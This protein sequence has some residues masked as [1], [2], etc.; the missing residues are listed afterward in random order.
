MEN[1]KKTYVFN[2]SGFRKFVLFL[3]KVFMGLIVDLEIENSDFAEYDGAIMFS[4]NHVSNYDG[5]L[6]QL[7]IRRPLCFM[8]K[9]ELFRNPVFGWVLNK[10]GSFPIRRGEF[11]RQAII[12]AKGILDS[13]LALMMFPEG[14]RTFGKGMVEA[15]T[16]TAYLAMRAKC[17]I[18]PVALIGVEDISK[19]R[20]KRSRVKVV[21]CERIIPGEKET[22]GELTNRLMKTIA[23]HLPA[24]LRGFYA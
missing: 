16:G 13:G 12:N 8:S 9:A 24:H 6:L 19:N 15:R 17:P 10:I 7:A 2:N 21:F 20:F 4:A 1:Q 23:A 11:D 14:T 5:I 18:V 3:L 22:A